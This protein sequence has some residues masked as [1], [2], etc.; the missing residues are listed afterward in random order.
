MTMSVW[1]PVGIL[2]SSFIPGVLIFFQPEERHRLRT[3]LNLLGA[4]VKLLLVGVLIWGVFHEQV[5]ET[6]W[7]LAPGL[8]FVLHADALSVL[9]VSLSTL[10]WLVTTIY[11]IG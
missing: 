3:L 5:F 11:A 7:F 4:L 2:L 9:F 1:L 8:E 6:R 10:L